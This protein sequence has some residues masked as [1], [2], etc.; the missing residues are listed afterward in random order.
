MTPTPEAI[1]AALKAI[2]DEVG[3][4]CC[5]WRDH[6]RFCPRGAG[7]T[8]CFCEDAAK[9]ALAAYE[10]A[11]EAAGWVRV[12]VEPTETMLAETG[13]PVVQMEEIYRA[14]IATRPTKES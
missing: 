4:R 12:P 5:S 7:G 8:F 9:V 13:W 3:S 1:E 11:M 14:M 2:R 10:S 6:E